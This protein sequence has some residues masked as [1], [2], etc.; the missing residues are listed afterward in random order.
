MKKKLTA[1]D[2]RAL[3]AEKRQESIEQAK[4]KREQEEAE[5]K[6]KQEKA[7]REK[8]REK[9]RKEVEK[10]AE[11][12]AAEDKSMATP[13]SSAKAAG[14][15]S[16]FI[17]NQD[18]LFMTSFGNGPDACPEKYIE[19]SGDSIIDATDS[20]SLQVTKD[21]IKFQVS[22]RVK[23]RKP[24]LSD[25]PLRAYTTSNEKKKFVEEGC[26]KIDKRNPGDD[27]IH[28]RKQ[29]E[30]IYFGKNFEDNIHIQLI[31]SIMDIE[32][33][34]APHVNN[35]VFELDNLLREEEG[36][37]DDLIGYMGFRKSYEKFKESSVYEQFLEL[38]K[39][40]QLGYF[41]SRMLAPKTKT[42][43]IDES[44][45]PEYEQKM[46]YL[47]SM[48]GEVRQATAHG[49]IKAR[50]SLYTLEKSCKKNMVKAKEHLDKIYSGAV[51]NLNKDFVTNCKNDMYILS[52]IYREWDV[53]TIAEKYYSFVVRK[54]YKNLGFSIRKL[55]EA[56]LEGDALFLKDTTY[57]TV[58]RRINRLLDFAITQYYLKDENKEWTDELKDL[59]RSSENEATKLAIYRTEANKKLYPAIK[60]IVELHIA[61]I[62][63]NYIRSIEGAECD[64]NLFAGVE[65]PTKAHFF[66]EIIYLLT[67]FLDGKEINE[68][69][70]KLI[71]RFDN[72]NSFLEVLRLEQLDDRLMPDYEMFYDSKEIA[73]ELR[74]INN[75][76]KMTKPDAL[77]K[78]V[79][80][81][82]AAELL[83]YDD[84]E[85]LSRYIDIMLDKKGTSWE[86]AG[87]KDLGFRNFIANNVIESPRFHYLVR[88]GNPKKLRAIAQNEKVIGYVLTN[89]IPDNQILR[90]YNSCNG[91]NLDLNTQYSEEQYAE[92]RKDLQIKIMEVNFSRYSK[93]PSGKNR[94]QTAAEKKF[95]EESKNIIRLY[96]TVLY[97]LLKNLVNINARYFQ[98]FHF[99]EKDYI[100]YH[101][102]DGK[103]K[104]ME[105]LKQDYASFARD[106]VRE[107]PLNYRAQKYVQ[108]NFN[109]SDKWALR[110]YRNCCDHLTAIR[111][112]NEY[113]GDI[114]EINSYYELFHYLVQR[115][116]MDQYKF[117]S[118]RPSTINE[119]HMIAEREFMNKKLFDYFDNVKKYRVYCKD[120]VKALNAPFAYNLSRFKNLSIKE[121]FDQNDYLPDKAKEWATD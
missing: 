26:W 31:Y 115:C 25:N 44:K 56:L 120:F 45:W 67:I 85:G 55:R 33:V 27:L 99:L 2:R 104:T 106:F 96:L 13:G 1:K 91:K 63:G 105:E 76:A 3:L 29:L 24:A 83:G 121:L 16:T 110:A 77:T 116:I 38:I 100:V 102:M 108:I 58:R 40:P 72:I 42:G 103:N 10:E 117:D 119:G 32:K 65:L 6:E 17:L 109:N 5:Q 86:G 101:Y 35:I 98:A 11:K 37:H 22:G 88:F 21:K 54:D 118:H 12:I 114:K 66:S 71:N 47:F 84:E 59:L 80:F 93:I 70:T 61:K 60:E 81:M 75:T 51:S 62:D 94:Y 97:L 79:M 64:E 20:P 9:Y 89:A 15:K 34:L 111:N 90:Y 92:M 52:Q 19:N 4:V 41:G 107:H 87:I 23:E 57:D 78:K 14:L 74:V 68:L 73:G 112:A 46:F 36:E 69:L 28:C 82:E 7:R 50:A 8:E 48:L 53:K 95:K 113:I 43:K 18:K 30:Q 49:E 39:K